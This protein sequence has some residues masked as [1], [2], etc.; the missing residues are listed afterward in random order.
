MIKHKK[1]LLWLLL[2]LLAAAI[3][4]SLPGLVSNYMLRVLNMMMITYLCVLSLFVVNGM[5]GQS[6]FAQAGLWGVGA[7]ITAIATVRG[8]LPPVVGMLLSIVGTALLAFLVG[9]PL[10]RLKRYYFTFSTVGVMMILNSLFLNWTPVTGGAM[11]MANVPPFS[12]GGLVMK[13]EGNNFYLILVISAAVSAVIWV[14]YRSALGR[15]FM[16]I[17]DNEIAANCMGVNS[18][19]TKDLSFAISGAI[20]GLA[21]SLFA[22]LAGYLSS[23]TF[24]YSQSTM[25]LVML[26]VGGSSSPV[27]PIV[28]STLLSLLP[29]WFRALQDYMMLIYGVGVM[30][31]MVVLP[32][33]LVGGGRKLCEKLAGKRT[34]SADAE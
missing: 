24:S 22:F 20:C 17:R 11:G 30:I 4:L 6:S 3:V 5:C 8:G 21:G 16:A 9:L 18:L 15:S 12:I 13:T 26:M 34:D 10:F 14:L 25:Y 23:T 29:E 19:L 28:G 27:G 33:G 31:L 1:K 32:D 2:P 7:Y